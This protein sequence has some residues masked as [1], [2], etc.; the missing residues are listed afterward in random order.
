MKNTAKMKKP[1]YEK[2]MAISLSGV[3]QGAC[4]LGSAYTDARCKS[5]LSA[6]GNCQFGSSA[7]S[8]CKSG[9][10]VVGNCKQGTN[11]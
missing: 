4:S 3:A 1:M 8:D 2:P 7:D 9:A 11:P 6:G 10:S 5:G